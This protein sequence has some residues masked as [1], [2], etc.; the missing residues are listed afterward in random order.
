ML[1]LRWQAAIMLAAA[2]LPA[3]EAPA[4]LSPAERAIARTRAWIV[5]EPRKAEAY[6]AL[7]MALARRARETADPSR[8]AEA[9]AALK[10]SFELVPENFE[11]QKVHAWVLLCR[12]EFAAALN[13]RMPDDEMVYMLL[14]DAHVELGAYKEAEEAAKLGLT[15]RPNPAL[16]PGTVPRVQAVL[17]D[18]WDVPA[19][20]DAVASIWWKPGLQRVAHGH[21]MAPGSGQP[22]ATSPGSVEKPQAPRGSGGGAPPR[23]RKLKM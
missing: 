12:H 2:A 23:K 20:P 11:G 10:T 1:A 17:E 15:H 21:A 14:V 3:G 22:R 19:C 7:A 18:R 5:K 6:N 16:R 9:Q 4:P 13:K 8:Y